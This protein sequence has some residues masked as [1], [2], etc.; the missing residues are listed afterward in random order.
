METKLKIPFDFNPTAG[1]SALTVYAPETKDCESANIKRGLINIL[2]F[3]D[4]NAK[5][6]SKISKLSSS[7]NCSETVDTE[8]ESETEVNLLRRTDMRENGWPINNCSQW[9]HQDAETVGIRRLRKHGSLSPY[10]NKTLETKVTKSKDGTETP[11]ILIKVTEEV[12]LDFQLKTVFESGIFDE[13]TARTVLELKEVRDPTPEVTPS[14]SPSRQLFTE[15]TNKRVTHDPVEEQPE[16]LKKAQESF[17][18]LKESLKKLDTNPHLEDQEA[19][20][21]MLDLTGKL[22]PLKKDSIKTLYKELDDSELKSAFFQILG[23]VGTEEAVDAVKEILYEEHAANNIAIYDQAASFYENIDSRAPDVSSKKARELMELLPEVQAMPA[24]PSRDRLRSA[25]ALKS[26][27][28]H[29]QKCFRMSDN[30]CI[31]DDAL[32]ETRPSSLLK[33][34][35]GKILFAKVLQNWA[36]KTSWLIDVIADKTNPIM[37][38]T[39]AIRAFE[40]SSRS[41]QP[42]LKETMTQLFYDRSEDHEIRILAFLTIHSINWNTDG[43]ERMKLV[44]YLIENQDKE[45]RQLVSYIISYMKE[46]VP[47]N[48]YKELGPQDIFDSGIYS[49]AN[50]SISVMSSKTD[51]LPR[52]LYF[53]ISDPLQNRGYILQTVSNGVFYDN[54]SKIKASHDKSKGATNESNAAVKS[55]LEK[56]SLKLREVPRIHHSR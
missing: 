38:R 31:T 54:I 37:L 22:K 20:F 36:L 47:K 39:Q 42:S 19:A 10:I 17:T 8:S 1:D 56:S 27:S 43:K 18:K 32:W 9:M 3:Y 16:L 45:D 50:S 6:I 24:S 52:T 28:L 53:R 21:V 5:T 46:F 44:E 2:E 14:G 11:K 7:G 26:S 34:T 40:Y 49:M 35:Q 23:A 4:S 30:D 25:I 13:F 33:D 55:A 41:A 29:A 51:I 15:V 12:I 48:T